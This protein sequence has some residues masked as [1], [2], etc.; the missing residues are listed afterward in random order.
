MSKKTKQENE[1][2]VPPEQSQCMALARRLH[3]AAAKKDE[4]EQIIALLRKLG[5]GVVVTVVNSADGHIANKIQSTGF[6]FYQD[7]Q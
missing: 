4:G 6:T 3:A 5:A 7:V 1:Q 2:I